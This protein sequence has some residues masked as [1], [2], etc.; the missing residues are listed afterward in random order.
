MLAY[1]RERGLVTDVDAGRPADQVA[2]EVDGDHRQ[3]GDEMIIRKSDREV[4]TMARAGEVVAETLTLLEREAQPGVTLAALD[5]MAE[6]HIRS[7]GGV[8]SFKG[9]RGFPGSICAS[10]NAMVVH[11]IPGPYTL[12]PA[13]CCRSTWA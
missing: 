5:A 8:P 7:R 2:A 12:E 4:E 11:G 6:A 9:F 13:I 1:Y 10:P 3:A